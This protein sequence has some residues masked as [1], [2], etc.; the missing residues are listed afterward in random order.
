MPTFGAPRTT[1][2]RQCLGLAR[3]I[4]R[5]SRGLLDRRSVETEERSSCRLLLTLTVLTAGAAGREF[6]VLKTPSTG[7]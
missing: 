7:W 2:L 4:S 1:T 3:P 6:N 5:R